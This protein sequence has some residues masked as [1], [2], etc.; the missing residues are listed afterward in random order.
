MSTVVELPRDALP[1]YACST[2]ALRH[3]FDLG[4][5]RLLNCRE[6]APDQL[7]SVVL[8]NALGVKVHRWP[9][10]LD[11]DGHVA[12]SANYHGDCSVILV[13]IESGFIDVGPLE[14]AIGQHLKRARRTTCSSNSLFDVGST[15]VYH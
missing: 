12:A 7:R 11:E 9:V 8:A 14:A 5:A 1:E 3:V 10:F 6:G 2:L 4:G 13:K 15:G